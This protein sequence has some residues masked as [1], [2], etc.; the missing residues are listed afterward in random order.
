MFSN[1]GHNYM[2][3]GLAWLL[4]GCILFYTV[5]LDWQVVYPIVYPILHRSMSWMLWMQRN[6]CGIVAATFKMMVKSSTRYASMLAVVKPKQTRVTAATPHVNT[7][8]SYPAPCKLSPLTHPEILLMSEW[9]RCLHLKQV[10]ITLSVESPDIQM[11]RK[12][13]GHVWKRRISA[14]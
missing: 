9:H 6:M 13:R 7:P 11:Q 1:E 3:V 4:S 2:S 14:I 12:C 5:F 10:W 8:T